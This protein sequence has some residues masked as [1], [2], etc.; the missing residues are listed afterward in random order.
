MGISLRAWPD[1]AEVMVG[2]W[3]N[4]RVGFAAY[5]V[6]LLFVTFVIAGTFKG[7]LHPAF[8]IGVLIVLLAFVWAKFFRP[9]WRSIGGDEQLIPELK[10]SD[11]KHP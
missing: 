3:M 5:W 8:P 1:R 4:T 2:R 9:A 10:P 6:F 7:G 11:L